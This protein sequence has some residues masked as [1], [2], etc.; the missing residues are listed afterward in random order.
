M[1]MINSSTGKKKT[2]IATVVLSKSKKH[3]FTI[4]GI[5]AKDYFQSHHYDIG[6]IFIP[7]L[8]IGLDPKDFA[9]SMKVCGGGISS[10]M[11]AVR[12]AIAKA[13]SVLNPE[14]RPQIKKLGFLTRD[15]RIV[16]RKKP[17][18]RKARRKE[19]FSKR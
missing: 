19:Q 16:E 10:Q 13:L 15:S 17:G 11:V 12:H 4:N 8:S 7:F 3:S 14:S 5:E 1:S 6:F 9:L 2:S 18:L